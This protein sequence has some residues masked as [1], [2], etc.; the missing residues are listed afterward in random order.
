MYLFCVMENNKK[1]SFKLLLPVYFLL[2]CSVQLQAQSLKS[3]TGKASFYHEKFDGRTTANGEIFDNADFTCAH[4]N[5]PFGTI[6][7]VV[8]PKNGERVIVRVNDRGPYTEGRVLDLSYEAAKKLGF[9]KKGV[10]DVKARVIPPQNIL[11]PTSQNV[12]SP[13]DSFYENNK[14]RYLYPIVDSKKDMKR[15]IYKM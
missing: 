5:L 8:N 9:T 1:S 13:L 3:F 2:I 15:Y 4:K 12:S 14:K 10:S 11:Y 7:E 6:L